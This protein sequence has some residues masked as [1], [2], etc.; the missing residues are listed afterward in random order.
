MTKGSGIPTE[1]PIVTPRP[2]AR[3]YTVTT[4]HVFCS[5]TRQKA[6]NKKKLNNYLFQQVNIKQRNNFSILYTTI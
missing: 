5:S 3:L 1:S 4:I 2:L 6:L